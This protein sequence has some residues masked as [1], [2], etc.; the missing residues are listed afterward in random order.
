MQSPI[1]TAPGKS[2]LI[3]WHHRHTRDALVLLATGMATFA[4][5]HFYDLPPQL[6]Q[7]G[8]DYA[9]WEMDDLIFVVFML[10]VG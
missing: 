3:D 10:S 2:R 7:F 4:L 8:L 6:L 5:A 1:R 9:D